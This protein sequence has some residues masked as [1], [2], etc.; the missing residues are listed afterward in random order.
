MVRNIVDGIWSWLKSVSVSIGIGILYTLSTLGVIAYFIKYI[1]SLTSGQPSVSPLELAAA[2]GGLCGLILLG[3]FYQ[4]GSQIEYSL[5]FTA[6]LFLTATVSFV[7]A[8]FLLELVSMIR[9]ETLN[10]AGWIAVIVTDIVIAC[11]GISLIAAL[12]YSIS[13]LRKL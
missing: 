4:K 13:L 6:K 12:V 1:A 8:F 9:S 7:I 3:A 5:K 10:A 11:G 2:S